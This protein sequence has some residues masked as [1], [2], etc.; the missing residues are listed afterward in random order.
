[1]QI[2]CLRLARKIYSKT[3]KLTENQ[4]EGTA[5]MAKEPVKVQCRERINGTC[6]HWCKDGDI[7]DK[8]I[9]SG[10]YFYCPQ[11]GHK[12]RCERVVDGEKKEDNEIDAM[13]VRFGE[14]I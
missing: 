8:T 14:M 7:H 10:C 1:M 3:R 9:F 13:H 5:K 4:D 2:L 12:V 6:G 11:I